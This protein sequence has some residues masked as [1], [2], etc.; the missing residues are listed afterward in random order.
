MGVPLGGRLNGLKASNSS[1]FGHFRRSCG[2]S[3]P[4]GRGGGW[5]GVVL[6]GAFLE[7]SWSSSP[8]ICILGWVAGA[9]GGDGGG[10]GGG[11]FGFSAPC[12]ANFS[13]GSR[14][15]SKML[16]WPS[17]LFP[18]IVEIPDVRLNGFGAP[19]LQGV[20]G[21]AGVVG[22]LLLG[23]APPNVAGCAGVAVLWLGTAPTLGIACAGVVWFLFAR[24]VGTAGDCVGAGVSRLGELETSG[25]VGS[26][27]GVVFRSGMTPPELVHCCD[28][29]VFA[30]PTQAA[31]SST[32]MDCAGVASCWLEVPPEAVVGCAG[33][34]LSPAWLLPGIEVAFA[35]CIPAPFALDPHADV[36][37]AGCILPPFI[38]PPQEDVGPV[39]PG[40]VVEPPFS[41]PDLVCPGSVPEPNLP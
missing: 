2:N 14:P 34:N 38:P 1:T 30:L 27:G 7:K 19:A 24:S 40:I 16:V 3:A 23:L 33:G 12:M 5:A 28:F 37:W 9:R 4:G 31:G 26:A 41:Q 11:G 21:V 15:V 18:G 32:V 25:T 39:T 36:P 10:G 35:G 17:V 13:W 29:N 8:G 6:I 20:F 22:P